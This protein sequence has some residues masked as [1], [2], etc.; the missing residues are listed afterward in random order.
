MLQY[1]Y[2]L[3]SVLFALDILSSH[4]YLYQTYRAATPVTTGSNYS[5]QC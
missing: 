2:L 4:S 3:L 1:Q 5:S